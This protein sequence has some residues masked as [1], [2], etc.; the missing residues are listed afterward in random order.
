MLCHGPSLV[1]VNREGVLIGS[2]YVE[3]VRDV[4]SGFRHRID[5]ESFLHQRVGK[6]PSDGGVINGIGPT[7]CALCLWHDKGRAAHALHTSRNQQ[8]RIAAAQSARGHA[9]RVQAGATKPIYSCTWDF[10]G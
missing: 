2:G 8:I 1:T 4:L 10:N 9:Y 3:V 5:T 7:E 6:T